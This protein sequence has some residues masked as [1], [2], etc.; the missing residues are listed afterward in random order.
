MS[1]EDIVPVLQG[2]ASAYG[3]VAASK[4]L[5]TQHRLRI[6]GVRKG[7]ADILLQV[8]HALGDVSPQLQALG[9][10]GGSAVFVV[11]TI[12]GVIRLRKHVKRK[13]FSERIGSNNFIV[14]SNSD[15]V[16]IEVSS[17][18][19][20]VF[21]SGLIDPD[22]NKITRPLVQGKIN[23]AQIIASHGGDTESERISVDER[24]LFEL[25]ELTVT[26]TKE[27]TLTGQFNSLTKSTL[28][29]YFNLLDGSRVFYEYRG[30][31]PEQFPSIF[32]K[33]GPVRVRCIAYLDENLKVN[34]LEIFDVEHIQGDLFPEM[35]EPGTE[36]P[37]TPPKSSAD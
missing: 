14:V 26:S 6:T 35:S 19:Y 18:V 32:A 31:H 8:W 28:A 36:T 15:N 10:I 5:E 29:G 16:T 33:S 4:N 2:F 12:L 11:T 34:K 27:T 3:K 9:V 7:S 1:V 23:A 37:P 13:P 25:G 21:K 24:P 17:D 30:E 20:N 22:L